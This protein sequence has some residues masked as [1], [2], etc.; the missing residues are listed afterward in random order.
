MHKNDV[1]CFKGL[2]YPLSPVFVYFNN[3]L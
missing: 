2:A 3:T 1:N